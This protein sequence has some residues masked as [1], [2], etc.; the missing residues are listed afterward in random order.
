VFHTFLLALLE[1][2]KRATYG[3]SE[4]ARLIQHDVPSGGAAFF[5]LLSYKGVESDR[6]GS[7]ELGPHGKATTGGAFSGR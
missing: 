2:I 4:M 7:V 3:I 5:A 1:E 6:K